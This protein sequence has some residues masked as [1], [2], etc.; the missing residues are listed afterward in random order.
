MEMVVIGFIGPKFLNL[1][2]QES[3]IL[4]SVL[5]A[6]SPAVVVP[7][8][9]KMIKNKRGTNKGVPQMIITG[10][11]LDDIF[12]IVCFTSLLTIEAGDSLNVMTFINVPLSIILGVGIRIL[13]GLILSIFFNK[14]HMRDSL[15]VTLILGICFAYAF[16][17]SYIFQWIG[18]SSLLACITTGITLSAK[19]SLQAHRIAQKCDTLRSVSEIF[20]FVLV[21]ASIQIKLMLNFI[22]PVILVIVIGL[23]FKFIATYS[24]M[25][26]TNLNYKERIFVSISYLPKATVQATIGGGMLDLGNKLN[27]QGIIDAGNIVLLVSVVAILFTAP[28]GALT[29]DLMT[30]KLITR[31]FLLQIEITK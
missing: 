29:I 20:L 3:F 15:K 27:N 21:G 4:G 18:F 23:T 22:L 6:V 26:K 13:T 11:S 10:S 2:Y 14:I 16:L 30:Y 5:E 25:F 24:C 12:M 17:E 9:I 31:D 8:M 1:T 28:L 7:H 19:N